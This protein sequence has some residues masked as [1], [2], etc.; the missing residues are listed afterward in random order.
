MVVSGRGSAITAE[1][2]M[3]RVAAKRI[4]LFMLR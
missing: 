4:G 3:V 2:R 1:G